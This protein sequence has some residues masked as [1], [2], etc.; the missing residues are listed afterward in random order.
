MIPSYFK[1]PKLRISFCKLVFEIVFWWPNIC[2]KWL[3]FQISVYAVPSLC[4]TGDTK[5]SHYLHWWPQRSAYYESGF[6]LRVLWFG[7]ILRYGAVRVQN[8]QKL[9]SWF[10]DYE[11]DDDID[12]ETERRMGLLFPSEEPF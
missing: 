3:G 6:V 9:S 11:P 7:F 8:R 10:D 1:K 12:F 4:G 5:L 2:L